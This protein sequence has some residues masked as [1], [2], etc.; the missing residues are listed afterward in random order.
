MSQDQNRVVA[1]I[2]IGVNRENQEVVIVI[3]KAST[4]LN[5]SLSATMELLSFIANAAGVLI[6]GDSQPSDE[7]GGGQCLN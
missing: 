4:K 7:D 1:D 3:P 2:C 6:N 5:L